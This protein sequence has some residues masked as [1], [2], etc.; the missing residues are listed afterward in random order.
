METVLTEILE[1]QQQVNQKLSS[2]T[3]VVMELHDKINST[4]HEL[5]ESRFNQINEQFEQIQEP[6]KHS[7]KLFFPAKEINQLTHAKWA[8]P[9]GLAEQAL[10]WEAQ[11]QRQLKLLQEAMQKEKEATKLQKKAAGK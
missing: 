8:D 2:F 9:K 10:A 6:T 4:D 5:G 11:Q 3:S 7:G 1:E